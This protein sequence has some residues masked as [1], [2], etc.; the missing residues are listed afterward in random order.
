MGGRC[1]HNDD[2]ERT[3]AALRLWEDFP[4]GRVILKH[5][6]PILTTETVLRGLIIH[7]L[8]N[9]LFLFHTNLG[10]SASTSK[11]NRNVGTGENT[12]W[13]F[14][15][16]SLQN[17]QY[18]SAIE[19][20]WTLKRSCYGFGC[21]V[22]LTSGDGLGPGDGRDCVDGR[23]TG[24]KGQAAQLWMLTRGMMSERETRFCVIRILMCGHTCVA[25]V[26]ESHQTCVL[27]NFY[28]LF[29]IWGIYMYSFLGVFC[30]KY[31]QRYWLA[32][33]I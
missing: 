21:K 17:A 20:V 23:V 12:R 19:R 30:C 33:K 11:R 25:F 27:I 3:Q 22:M 18:F 13:S 15:V 26:R 32:I 4:D 8:L 5:Q 28:A 6:I 31:I 16:M 14:R 1:L 2:S 7:P 9:L 24:E 29:P 10:H